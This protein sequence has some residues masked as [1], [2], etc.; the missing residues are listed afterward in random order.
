M[1][2]DDDA[3]AALSAAGVG[4]LLDRLQAQ[5]VDKESLAD[6]LERMQHSPETAWCR[7]VD[8]RYD[9]DYGAVAAVSGAVIAEHRAEW[10]A[11]LSVKAHVIEQRDNN[12]KAW[13]ECNRRSIDLT[14]E[15]DAALARV[16]ELEKALDQAESLVRLFN[17]HLTGDGG[18]GGRPIKL[19]C[20]ECEG[21]MVEY[22]AARAALGVPPQG[23]SPT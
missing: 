22:L 8:G 18:F 14:A 13:V 15:R 3:R 10:D 11:L 2:S 16:A 9:I 7:I 4:E 19:P 23:D 21:R 6:R 12:M 1:P 20:A 17:D 5:A